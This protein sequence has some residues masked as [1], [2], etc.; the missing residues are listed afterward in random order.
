MIHNETDDSFAVDNSERPHTIDA[1]LDRRTFLKGAIASAA[2]AGGGELLSGCTSQPEF[3]AEYLARSGVDMQERLIS[4]ETNLIKEG[5]WN[6]IGAKQT[7][8]GLE[9]S[10]IHAS[11]EDRDTGDY[12]ADPPINLFGT[13]LRV[14]KE[15]TLTI[16]VSN[17]NGIALQC[18]GQLPLIRDD[19]RIENKSIRMQLNSD[20]VHVLSW[21]NDDNLLDDERFAV[22]PSTEN[23]RQLTLRHEEDQLSILIDGKVI[24]RVDENGIFSQ[25]TLWLGLDTRH[26]KAIVSQLRISAPEDVTVVDTTSLTV[27]KMPGGLQP[28]ASK[29]NDSLRMGVTVA[30]GPL[31]ENTVYDAIVFGGNYGSITM[32]NALKPVHIMPQPGITTFEEADKIIDLAGRHGMDVHGHTLVFAESLPEWMR[33]LPT[34]S[35]A[36]KRAVRQVMTEYITTVVAHFRGRIKS[37]DVINEPLAPV[38]GDEPTWHDHLWYEAMGKDYIE[39]AL[40]TVR[41]VDPDAMLFVNENTLENNDD[42]ASRNRWKFLMREIVIPMQKKGLIDGVGMQGHVAKLPRDAIDAA[43]ISAHLH[44]LNTYNLLGRVSEIDVD[45]KNLNAQAKQY[46][47]ALGACLAAKNCVGF[48]SWGVMGGYE[49][50]GLPWDKD[51]KALPAIAAMRK[52][53]Q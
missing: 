52:I 10:P 12:Q 50:Q 24:G 45:T 36:E 15:W 39:I 22:H 14:P 35:A 3:D 2:L 4:P 40:H 1:S 28:L 21:Q 49:N 44:E 34:D 7:A 26:E 27:K 30:P 42:D 37:W 29:K 11:V 5:V 13:H 25:R 41:Q 47:G 16:S 9:I 53:L 8:A 31:V 48:T 38:D 19:Y 46:A 6:M 23:E 20:H 18:Y 33:N 17:T 51:G 43:S 32:E